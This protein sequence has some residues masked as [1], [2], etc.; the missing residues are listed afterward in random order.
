MSHLHGVIDADKHFVI[1]PA[2]RG[3]ANES[4]KVLLMQGDHKSEVFTFEM[5]RYIDGHDTSLC[6]DVKVHYINAKA[7][8]TVKSTDVHTVADLRVSPDDENV[9]IF[10][11]LVEKPATKYEGMLA[12]RLTFRC[13]SDGGEID[14]E[15]NTAKYSGISIGEGSR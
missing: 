15:W 12:F 14:Y 6:N 13:I 2:T 7:D 5:P 11:W 10:S 8:K 1:D 9:V 4:G 3:I